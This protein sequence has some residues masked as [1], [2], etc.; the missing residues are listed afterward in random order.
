MS[1][2]FKYLVR[3]FHYLNFFF[4]FIVPDF[5]I[6]TFGCSIISCRSCLSLLFVISSLFYLVFPLPPETNISAVDSICIFNIPS[7]LVNIWNNLPTRGVESNTI[8]RLIKDK[9]NTSLPVQVCCYMHLRSYKGNLLVFLLTYL[10]AFLF[11]PH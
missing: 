3:S 9:M 8:I 11:F 2:L 5:P 1:F 7:F 4:P 6:L 10:L